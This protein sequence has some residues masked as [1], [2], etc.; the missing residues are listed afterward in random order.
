[1]AGGGDGVVKVAVTM[2]SVPVY[3]RGGYIVPRRERPRRSTAAMA[4]DP[5][6]LVCFKPHPDGAQTLSTHQRWVH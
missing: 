3:L 6:T 4:A 2:D 5:F 1:M